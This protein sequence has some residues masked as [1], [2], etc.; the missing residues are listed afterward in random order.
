MT[1]LTTKETSDD[2][3]AWDVP[4]VRQCLRCKSTFSSEWSG[5]RI[6]PRCKASNAWRNG[7]PPRS[8]PFA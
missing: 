1:C 2:R 4:K 8:Y 6:C 3:M 5:E 7:A